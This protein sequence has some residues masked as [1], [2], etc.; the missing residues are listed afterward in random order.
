MEKLY[1]LNT[2]LKMAY[3]GRDAFPTSPPD[4]PLPAPITMFLTTTPNSRFGFITMWGKFCQS[5]FEI[6]ARTALAQFGHFIL[7]ARVWLQPPFP[8]GA[9]LTKLNIII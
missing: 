2:C 3:T 8:L 5:C 4:Q 1:S 9:S 7:K 6:T